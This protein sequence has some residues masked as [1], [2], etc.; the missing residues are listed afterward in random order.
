MIWP[1]QRFIDV[2]L[3]AGVGAALPYLE[4]RVRD[5]M[6][7]SAVEGDREHVIATAQRIIEEWESR[8]GHPTYGGERKEANRSEMLTLLG[9]IADATLLDRFVDGVVTRD[10]DG[11]E[12]EALV[13]QLHLLEAAKASD[14]LTRLALDNTADLTVAYVD[15]LSRLVAQA[16]RKFL[17]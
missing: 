7:P 10:Y 6:A 14:L 16:V 9:A 12:N 3:Q 4:D 13:A 15:L 2:L 8:V 1:K 5:S 11:T 17:R